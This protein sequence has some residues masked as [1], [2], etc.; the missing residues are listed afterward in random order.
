LKIGF[1]STFPP[2]N[3]GIAVYA[4]LLAEAVLD[5]DPAVEICVLAET[6]ARARTGD[7][8]EVKV[9][10]DRSD[11]YLSSILSD[12]KESGVDL[13][14]FQ[15]APELYGNENRLL[16]LVSALAASGI[17][18][19]VTLH[20]VRGA[21]WHRALSFSRPTALFHR[22]LGEHAAIVVHHRSNA[23]ALER[24]GVAADKVAVIPHGTTRLETL[25]TG[26]A[27][28]R[29]ELPEDKVIFLFFGFVHAQ[30]NLHTPVAAFRRILK[31]HPDICFVMAGS[32]QAGQWYNELYARFLKRRLSR[33]IAQGQVF[34][35]QEFVPAELVSAYYS[36]ADVVLLPHAF[37]NYDSVSGIFHQAI[38]AKRPVIC[39]MSNKFKEVIDHMGEDS[40]VFVNPM[41]VKRW[42]RAIVKM[43]EDR[44]FRLQV[45]DKLI[46]YSKQTGWPDVA[47]AHLDLYQRVGSGR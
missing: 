35:R 42:G 19:V 16:S 37:Q 5:S 44:E 34:W 12:V 8:L 41:D 7:R 18:V 13:V 32:T 20:T 10:Y 6:G 24:Q 29:L 15:H 26:E 38:G 23:Q 3:C 2:K 40:G 27:R 39:S 25:P 1:V 17:P 28:R 30:K 11:D 33:G 21:R 36:A 14:H 46:A 31:A 22:D 45:R 4:N 43:A 47:R 9:T